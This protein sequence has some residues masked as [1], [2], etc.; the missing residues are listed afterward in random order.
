MFSPR[1]K[2]FLIHLGISLLLFLG[3]LY[4][5]VYVWYPPPFFAYD[6]GWQG[7]QLIIGVD[8]VLGPLLTLAVYNV[9]KAK[10]LLRRDLIIIGVIQISALIAGSW[11]VADQRTRLVIFAGDH[12]ISMTQTLINE[13]DVS[14][15]TL[16]SLKT[17]HPAM[18]Y[19]ELPTDP[20]ART[21]FINDSA[22]S[23]PVFK[24]GD[25]YR[26]LTAEAL[27]EAANYGFDLEETAQAVPELRDR[28]TAFLE[29][30]GKSSGE[31]SAIPVYC[32]Y[33]NPSMV[34]DRATGEMLDT[35]RVSHDQLL[36]TIIVRK[37]AEREAR[38][39]NQ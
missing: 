34:I 2:A 1:I 20:E 3:L 26:P 18:G 38:K 32:R 13:S 15:E 35:I 37:R 22:R 29:K 24:R 27:I 4:V 14:A 5:I 10:H 25:L 16:A 31:V 8:L 6:G 36:S 39:N 17:S 28:I 12:F 33:G 9:K 21:K 30:V 19:V 7:I 23:R 11:I